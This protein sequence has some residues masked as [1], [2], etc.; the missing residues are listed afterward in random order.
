LK[1]IGA[2]LAILSVLS[3]MTPNDPHNEAALFAGT[4][5]AIATLVG[6]YA[7]QDHEDG[8]RE[9][10]WRLRW[11]QSECAEY[12]K[13]HWKAEEGFRAL[14]SEQPRLIEDRA[15]RDEV[16]NRIAM[17]LLVALLACLYAVSKRGSIRRTDYALAVPCLELLSKNPDRV[18]SA[19]AK[20]LLGK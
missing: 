15:P 20:A 11:T 13:K 10:W 9:V 8:R 4:M 5:T 2:G 3:D 19:Q 7:A 6:W 12:V 16:F 1:N 17:E 18:V 14:L